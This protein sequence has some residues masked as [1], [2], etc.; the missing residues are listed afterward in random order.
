M[1]WGGHSLKASYV[2]Q[3]PW[4][5]SDEK[6]LARRARQ[7]GSLDFSRTIQ[8]YDFGAKIYAS[9]SR[10]DGATNNTLRGYSLWT[11]YAS[12]KLDSEWTARV[13][14]ENAL[15]RQYQ[16]A[17]GFNTLGRGIFATL[18]YQPK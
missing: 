15:D 14:L 3:D 7:Y 17:Y 10:P 13:K 6:A 12:K 4:N 18:Q 9:G 2:H 11:L 5:V 8:M 16:L 1:T